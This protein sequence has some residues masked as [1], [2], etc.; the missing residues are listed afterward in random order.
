MSAGTQARAMRIGEVADHTGL[1]PRTIRYY[2]EI[3]LFSCADGSA[4][5]QGKHRLYTVEDVEKLQELVRLRDLL[6][7]SLEQLSELVAAEAARAEIRREMRVT[8]DPARQRELVTEALRLVGNQLSLVRSRQA[9][10][11]QLEAHL[12]ER[13]RLGLAKLEALGD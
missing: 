4:R 5:E 3:G 10:L 13:Q 8:D 7:L 2:E 6:G 9:E 1:T 12:L 11:A